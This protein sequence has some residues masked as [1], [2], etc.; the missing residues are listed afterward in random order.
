MAN[1]TREQTNMPDRNTDPLSGEP[2]AHPV[3][4][5]VGAAVGG[6]AAG[7]AG[8]AVAGPIGAAAGAV[9]G[10]VAGGLAGKEVA[11]HYDPTVEDAYWKE[12]Y[13]TRPYYEAAVPYDEYQPA[14]RYGWESRAKSGNRTFDEAE[15]DLARN[16]E[17][18]KA[19]SKLTWDKAKFATK[20]AW[21]RLGD[22]NTGAACGVNK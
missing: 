8:G 4:A 12:N 20:D 6:A 15:S 10:G 2:G 1:T 19:K 13:R 21:N 5:G 16:W 11:E 22:R 18:A 7:A 17:A 9:I 14:Y 3:G